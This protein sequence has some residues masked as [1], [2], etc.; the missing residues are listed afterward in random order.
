M[1]LRRQEITRSRIFAI[2]ASPIG[3]V[4][5]RIPTGR[6]LFRRIREAFAKRFPWIRFYT[7]V[8]EIFIAATFSAQFGWWN[9]RLHQRSRLRHVAEAPLPGERS[10]HARDSRGSGPKLIFMQ[11]ESYAVFPSR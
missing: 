2:S 11:S 1:S 9:E 6:S 7:P 5:F 3:S 8:N 4:I 10:R